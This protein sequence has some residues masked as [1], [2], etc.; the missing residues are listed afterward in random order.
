VVLTV[1]LFRVECKKFSR[2]DD[3]LEM[4]SSECPAPADELEGRVFFTGAGLEHR[5]GVDRAQPDEQAVVSGQSVDEELETDEG[6]VRHFTQR[7]SA[8]KFPYHNISAHLYMHISS[9]SSSPP[10]PSSSN[11]FDY[12]KEKSVLRV[13]FALES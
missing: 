7:G 10:P 3:V 12:I 9:S 11:L 13:C 6:Q 8:Q 2:C 5:L 1:D 4:F